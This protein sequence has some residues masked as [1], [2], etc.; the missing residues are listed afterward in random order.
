MGYKTQSEDTTEAADR[1]WFENL[2]RLGPGKRLEIARNLSR[3][4]R[5]AAWSGLRR[6]NPHLSERELQVKAVEI[7]YGA[8]LAAQLEAALKERGQWT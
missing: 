1:L 8:E 3:R 6:A 5:N 4:Q 2:R 7:W